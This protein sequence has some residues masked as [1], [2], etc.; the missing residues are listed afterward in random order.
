MGAGKN[1]PRHPPTAQTP[2]H[3]PGSGTHG[4]PGRMVCS[5]R[6]VQPEGRPSAMASIPDGTPLTGEPDAGNP[7]V[8]F[9]GRGEVQIL[10]PTLFYRKPTTKKQ[11]WPTHA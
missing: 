9:G 2:G 1:A 7:P 3:G 11:Q 10:I 8:R 4:I 6:T 5:A